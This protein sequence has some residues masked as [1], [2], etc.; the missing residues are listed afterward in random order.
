MIM[1][2]QHKQTFKMNKEYKKQKASLCI[3]K[4]LE[5]ITK[6]L[7][8]KLESEYLMGKA[9]MM[10]WLINS[11]DQIKTLHKRLEDTDGVKLTEMQ[12]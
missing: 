4:E 9:E 12:K 5:D 3:H 7:T 6:Q 11:Y 10:T 2:D 8:G 1:T